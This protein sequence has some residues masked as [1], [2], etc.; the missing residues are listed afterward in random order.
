M[1][2]HDQHLSHDIVS[3]I[4]TYLPAKSFMRFKCITKAWNTTMQDPNIIRLHYARSQVRPSASRLLF[5]LNTR[6]KRHWGRGHESIDLWLQLDYFF[7]DEDMAICSNHC[8][9]FVCLY[10][11]KDSQLYLFNVTTREIKVFP[12]YVNEELRITPNFNCPFDKLVL[13][14]DQVT[15]NFKLLLLFTRDYTFEAKILTLGVT[16]STWRKIDLFTYRSISCDDFGDECIYLNGVVYL[17]WPEHYMVY[18]N[19]ADEEF[20]YVLPPP[21]TYFSH[22][23]I[24]DTAIWGKLAIYCIKRNS[25]QQYFGYVDIKKEVYI[26]LEKFYISRENLPVH[27]DVVAAL[28]GTE[29]MY[30]KTKNAYIFAT[31]SVVGAPASMP[32]NCIRFTEHSNIT[33]RPYANI[34]F[35]SKFVENITPLKY[36]LV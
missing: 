26:T 7:N 11:Y 24:M 30:D 32:V 10:S 8:N 29:K 35:V 13:G 25:D 12:T 27:I 9:G 34:T 20:G 15:E 31:T 17:G 16:N 6:P 3:E 14:F 4:L 2:T 5:Q 28:L 19:F 33:K 18:F 22:L 23:S 36:L 1:E 21:Q